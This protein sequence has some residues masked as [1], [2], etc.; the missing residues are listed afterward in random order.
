MKTNN[1]L[2]PSLWVLMVAI[3]IIIGLDQW[4]K[5]LATEYLQYAKPVYVLPVLNWTLLHNTG[6]AFSFL[7][8]QGGWQR[9]FFLVVSTVV[10]IAFLIWLVRLPKEQWIV[11]FSLTLIVGGAIGN[12]IDRASMG[13]VVDFIQC[14]WDN[15]YFPAFN[16]ADMAITGGAGFMIL[17][18]FFG[19]G[20]QESKE[21][22]A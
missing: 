20:E 21:S 9:W 15:K 6:A 3:V 13:Y 17:D 12:L 4:T 11:R 19:P 7:A 18:M 14:H 22:N 5:A 16:I 1:F 10:S 8:D 2:Q